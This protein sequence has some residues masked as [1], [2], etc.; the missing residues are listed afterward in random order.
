MPGLSIIV[1]GGDDQRFYGALETAMAAA[2]LGSP[3]R[4]FLQGEAVTLLREPVSV[5]G[6]PARKAAG[7]PELAWMIGE[8]AAMEVRLFVCQSGMALVGLTA[9]EMVSQAKAA[10]L[11]SFLRDIGEGDRL[12]VY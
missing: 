4:I 5:A 6:D 11:V 10:G 7:L 1:A 8:A 12:L 2:A 9:E 3:A